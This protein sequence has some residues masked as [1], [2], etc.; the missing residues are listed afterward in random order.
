[1]EDDNIGTI[2]LADIRDIFF[3]YHGVHATQSDT[4]ITS[5]RLVK[6]LEAMEGHP[7]AEFGRARKAITKNGLARLLKPYRIRPSTIRTGVGEHDTGKG[8][9]LSQFADAFARYLP[10]LPDQTV[11]PSH[12]ANEGHFRDSEAVTTPND[13]TV[14]KSQK[15]TNHTQCDGVT[16]AD[17][18]LPIE[19]ASWT[20]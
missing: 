16:D 3:N 10:S 5:E 18:D 13:V 17:A 9:R 20:V 14:Q 1:M 12:P 11:T 7:W 2:L 8:Y 15:P 6:A 19:E 4:Q